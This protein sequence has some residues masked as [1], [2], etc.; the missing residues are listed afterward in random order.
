MNGSWILYSW[1][2]FEIIQCKHVLGTKLSRT[3]RRDLP[4][5]RSFPTM[6]LLHQKTLCE[7]EIL[8]AQ[9]SLWVSLLPLA[10]SC[11][12]TLRRDD[13][14]HRATTLIIFFRTSRIYQI[15]VEDDGIHEAT[16]ISSI[17]WVPS[18]RWWSASLCNCL[19]Q[20]SSR[21]EKGY[22]GAQYNEQEKLYVMKKRYLDD[23]QE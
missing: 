7:Q 19:L 16:D 5:R 17:L 2:F 3:R 21:S 9:N 8:E 1:L 14:Q 20:K 12:L 18:Y 23:R 6:L 11:T 13:E 15:L 10:Y 4:W 22:E